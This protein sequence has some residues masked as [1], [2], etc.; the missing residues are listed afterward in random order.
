LLWVLLLSCSWPSFALAAEKR[1]IG[2]SNLVF[3]LDGEDEIGIAKE[4]FRIHILEQLRYHKLNA[5]GAE[6]LVFGRDNA[7]QAELVL[8]GTVTELQCQ[9]GEA[10]S[11]V[12]CRI[13]IE[14]QVLDVA[15]DSVVYKVLS[16]GRVLNVSKD[17]PVA[18]GKQ[19]I[20]SALVSVI[21][22]PKF[23]KLL[24]EE[25]PTTSERGYAAASLR[26]CA[27]SAKE[28]PAA[29]ESVLN[30]TVLVQTSTGFGSGFVLNPEGFVVTAAHV[31]TGPAVTVRLR[32]GREFPA[33]VVRLNRKLDI[34]LLRLAAAAG[35][36]FECLPIKREPIAVGADVY[37][38]GS[39]ATRDLSFSLARGIVSGVRLLDGVQYLQTDAAINRGNSGGPLVT[40]KGEAAAVVTFKLVGASMEGIGF[41]VP[42][43]VGLQALAVSPA[44]AASSPELLTTSSG[45]RPPSGVLV[46]DKTDAVP[47]L[48]DNMAAEHD[49]DVSTPSGPTKRNSTGMM[50]GG[51][52]MTSLTPVALLVAVA[53]SANKT[54]CQSRASNSFD[55]YGSTSEDC[56]KHNGAIYGGLLMGAVLAGVG[57]PLIV[58]GAKKV[59]ARPTA[60]LNPWLSP[61]S[62]GL[63]VHVDL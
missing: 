23:R 1:A 40:S 26:A 27:P 14:W 18:V 11:Q 53:G 12:S 16:R 62:A 10:S 21:Q 3:R 15:S 42:L 61:E 37:A 38:I 19:L 48:S 46:V 22:R 63:G 20:F 58:V 51:I 33:S 44:D 8:G 25:P 4:D 45:A 28:M 54:V 13:G 39:P 7:Q 43:P 34:A 36:V 55:R 35:E 49:T 31:V 50:V 17:R 29:T 47:A 57:I 41:G 6:N 56:S 59:P 60:T 5:V 30:A 32:D 2:F 52:V 9:P 24:Q